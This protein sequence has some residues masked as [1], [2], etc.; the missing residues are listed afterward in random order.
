MIDVARNSQDPNTSVAQQVRLAAS[1]EDSNPQAYKPE[2]KV[3]TKPMTATVAS[4]STKAESETPQD[5]I[6]STRHVDA[7]STTTMEGRMAAPIPPRPEPSRNPSGRAAGAQSSGN[8]PSR[9]EPRSLRS[10][11][12]PTSNIPARPPRE[13]AD[14][15]RSLDRAQEAIRERL[16]RNQTKQVSS[17]TAQPDYQGIVHHASLDRR[18]GRLTD[19]NEIR[20]PMVPT[21]QNERPYASRDRQPHEESPGNRRS[22]KSYMPHPPPNAISPQASIRGVANPQDTNKGR[23]DFNQSRGYG[24]A[25]LHE[26]P[27]YSDSAGTLDRHGQTASQSQYNTFRH[28]DGGG[29]NREDYRHPSD[30]YSAQGGR[31]Y[32]QPPQEGRLDQ[33]NHLSQIDG[34]RDYRNGSLDSENRFQARLPEPPRNHPSRQDP[35]YGR[36][37]NNIDTPA[38]PRTGPNDQPSGRPTRNSN[39]TQSHAGSTS[40]TSQRPG[41]T[42]SGGNNPQT[43]KGPSHGRSTTRNGVAP[44][45]PG[46]I[47]TQVPP[48]SDAPDTA[49]VHPDRLKAIQAL[50]ASPTEPSH[51]RVNNQV[52]APKSAVQPSQAAGPPRGPASQAYSPTSTAQNGFGVP[53]GPSNGVNRGD[54]RFAGIQGV[55]QQSGAAPTPDNNGQGTSI[56][57][58]GARN[59]NASEPSASNPGALPPVPRAE[60]SARENTLA[61]RISERV[62][63]DEQSYGH[64]RRRADVRDAFKEINPGIDGQRNRSP[65]GD[66]SYRMPPRDGE[67]RPYHRNDRQ[68]DVAQR[69]PTHELRR[70]ARNADDRRM[71]PERRDGGSWSDPRGAVPPERYDERDRREGGGSMRKRFRPG[72]EMMPERA[73]NHGDKRPRRMQ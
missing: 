13:V 46:A 45:H 10:D 54:K 12:P 7:K 9:I 11:V 65:T 40:A 72:D 47:S 53:N 21:S 30:Q 23:G 35:Q 4:A 42:P 69:P 56:R 26:G 17:S 48:A 15:R 36:L 44:P 38:G 33:R 22:D 29:P 1:S 60:V 57:G 51:Q 20:D 37:N 5:A 28:R 63:V 55:L 16:N 59:R 61:G 71:P 73:R 31:H 27:M 52:H 64:G 24:S 2:G 19:E 3:P 62:P 8:L 43:P 70:S 39:I 6:E 18:H 68:Q 66:Q 41:N 49:G 32:P 25:A 67:G 58:R 34:S 14:N 50:S